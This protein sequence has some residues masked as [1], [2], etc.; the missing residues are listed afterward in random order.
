MTQQKLKIISGRDINGFFGLVS[1]NMAIISFVC[2]ILLG[3]GFP[4]DIV[5]LRIVPG[6][7]LGVLIGDLV[8]SYFAYKMNKKL[9]RTDITAMPLGLDLPSSL[10]IAL[11]VVGP[12]FLAMK[13]NGIAAGEAAMKAWFIG[14][15]GIVTIGIL[16]VVAVPFANK[17]QNKVPLAGLLGSLA[18]VCVGLIG[19][20]ALVGI[21]SLPIVGIIAFGLVIYT[22]IAKIPLPK[23]IP[24]V[25]AAILVGTVLYH[26]LGNVSLLGCEYAVPALQLRCGFPLPTLGFI[27][28][29]IPA[30]DYF[31]I[32]IPFAIL[33]IVGDIN[34]TAS[35]AEAGDP[36]K[37][38]T[39]LL[40]DGITTVIAGICGSTS[41]TTAYIGQPAY[42]HMGSGLG[43]TILTGLF[44]GLGG[45]FGYVIFFVDLI[46][47]AVL[48][49]I[50]VFVAMDIISQAFH[51]SPRAHAPAVCLAIFPTV[52]RLLAINYT[53]TSIVPVEKL[54]TLMCAVSTKFPDVL[55]TIAMGNGFILVGMLWGGFLAEVIDRNLKKSSVYLFIL[56]ILTFFGLIHSTDPT[57]MA[58]LPWEISSVS[59]GF[60]YQLTIAYLMLSV[61]FFFL[62]YTKGVKENRDI[63][64]I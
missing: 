51:A 63:D 64:A 46:P 40:V 33:V 10:G 55:I 50:L 12:A 44:I 9:G 43:Y 27:H 45:M 14:M 57:G 54:H 2:A 23:R 41:Q 1:D 15:A 21:F 47:N 53:N 59:S 28:G 39:I 58:Y 7:A 56:G 61:M 25:F 42:K 49:P 31:P 36:Y 16:K 18:G 37:A 22:I 48:A 19:F 8:L 20:M 35:A 24:G 5:A 11:T 52:A 30:L 3:F 6:T 26:I 4:K 17:I 29:M 62:S 60:V 32:F 13:N 34:V 38:K